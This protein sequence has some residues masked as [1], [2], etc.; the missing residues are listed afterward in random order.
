RPLT[1]YNCLRASPTPEYTGCLS[2][3]SSLFQ[4]TRR[5]RSCRHRRYW[6][7]PQHTT[8]MSISPGSCRSPSIRY[9]K[10]YRADD[11]E[12]FE[13]VAIR[14]VFVQKYTDYVPYP[15]KTYFY[16]IAWV[17]YDYLESPFSDVIE[18]TTQVASDSA[19]LDFIQAAH[20]NYFAERA[21]VNSGMHAIH[22]GVDD[23]VVSV[24]ETGLSLLSHVVAAE[25]GFI[26]R[27]AAIDRLQRIVDFLARVERYHGA[28]PAK[29]NG[30]TGKAIFEVDSV[31]EADLT[32]TA[33]LMQG[34]LVSKQYF[35]ADSSA[36]GEAAAKIDS[37]WNGVEWSEFVVDGQE[38]ILL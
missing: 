20:F 32:A 6:H 22:F 21:E 5:G 36:L 28:F 30:R 34:L 25:R 33:F 13:P 2:I 37:L 24:M 19:L 16:K 1:V 23:A 12:H 29:V 11:N 27:K 4:R 8:G 10:V 18:V 31:P 26:S 3:K 7:L 14:P 15:E 38:N 17:D 35:A 9:I